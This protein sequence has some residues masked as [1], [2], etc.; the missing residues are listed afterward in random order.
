MPEE[1]LQD[2]GQIIAETA[3]HAYLWLKPVM[4]LV[5]ALV[6]GAIAHRILWRVLAR[7]LRKSDWWR[8]ALRRARNPARLAFAV[9]AV[10][11]ALPV[12]GLPAETQSA[13]A[14]LTTVALIALLG[15]AAILLTNLF[16]D[17][18]L[19]RHR[20]DEDDNLQARKFVTQVRVLRRTVNI[21]IFM[22]ATAFVLLSFDSVRKYGVSLFASAGVA[23]LAVGFAARPVL[24]NLIAGVQIA[25]TQPI[26]IEDVVIVE[27]EW[28][29]IEEIGATYVV[30]R[31]WDWRRLVV[32]LSYFIEKP[33]ENWTREGASI[34]GAVTWHVDYSVPIE[35][36]RE[37]MIAFV[38]ASP[39]WDGAV[40][41]MQMIEANEKTVVM[42]GLMSARN[43]M[44]AWELRCEIREKLIAWLQ[45]EYPSALPR[46]RAE[47]T[48]IDG[49]LEE[50]P[51]A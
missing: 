47:M 6:A 45:Q 38:R 32:P 37:K 34:I 44:I 8:H 12:S 2:A 11:L 39:R 3:D 9:L 35:A 14:H 15:W 25:L 4:V 27:G 23:G 16:T 13:I 18:M 22:I 46:F 29:W 28:G 17:R 31:I 41:N 42:R 43:S 24:A 1:I 19:R 51:A 50:A 48:R 36:L 21:L 33:F 26:R 40:V 10:T 49:K 30:V 20:L 7:V 5:L